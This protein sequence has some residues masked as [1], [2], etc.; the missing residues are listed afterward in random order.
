MEEET[1]EVEQEA[2]EYQKMAKDPMCVRQIVESKP[3]PIQPS[4]N[5]ASSRNNAEQ[6]THPSAVPADL[7]PII[8]RMQTRTDIDQHPFW[9]PTRFY[10]YAHSYT[11][12]F[13]ST[14]THLRTHTGINTPTV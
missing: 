14:Y 7:L 11:H 2:E 6:R 5:G 9:P 10:K 1:D 12:V 8:Y 4:S 13:I 3:T